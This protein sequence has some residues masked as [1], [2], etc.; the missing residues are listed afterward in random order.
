MRKRRA[1]LFDDEPIVLDM[2]KMFFELRGYDVIAYGEP[3]RCPVYEDHAR[4][5]NLRPCADVLITD[6]RMQK[7]T[8]IDMLAGQA[9]RGC[10]L[11]SR[12]KAVIS[13]FLDGSELRKI[14]ELGCAFLQKP[15]TPEE[16]EAWLIGCEERMDLTKPL[17]F[18]RKELREDFR[19]GASYRRDPAEQPCPATTVNRSGSGLCLKVEHAPVLHDVLTVMADIPLASKKAMVKWSKSAGDGGYYVGLSLC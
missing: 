7:M 9:S 8:G 12:N 5:G 14:E 1:I 2:L 10:K 19:V 13:G 18:K 3:V 6:N 11:T 16:M 15:F 4:C 17:G